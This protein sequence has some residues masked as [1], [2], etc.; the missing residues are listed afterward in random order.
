MLR[1]TECLGPVCNPLRIYL[2]IVNADA[3]EGNELPRF[4]CCSLRHNRNSYYAVPSSCSM[5]TRDVFSKGKSAH[6]WSLTSCLHLVQRLRKRG[7]MPLL[8]H[9]PV[10]C[11][12]GQLRLIL[13]VIL[14][15]VK[16]TAQY[17][18]TLH[19]RLVTFCDPNRKSELRTACGRVSDT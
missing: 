8:P 11:A 6:A 10:W 13:Y 15:N 7:V 16:G 4:Q 9:M 3:Y 12:K 2:E 14:R 5:A 18:C 17:M 19:V 1:Q